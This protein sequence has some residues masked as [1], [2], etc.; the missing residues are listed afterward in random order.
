MLVELS[1]AAAPVQKGFGEESCS[2]TATCRSQVTSTSLRLRCGR[3]QVKEANLH[4]ACLPRN[5]H[6]CSYTQQ[7]YFKN[8]SAFACRPHTLSYLSLGAK[9]AVLGQLTIGR[10]PTTWASVAAAAAAASRSHA[11]TELVMGGLQP[12]FPSVPVKSFNTCRHL[13]RRYLSYDME[14]QHHGSGCLAL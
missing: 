7:G 5:L 3:A 14:P 1:T 4:L 8:D 9:L 13:Y 12:T 6:V 2:Q 10:L 11:N